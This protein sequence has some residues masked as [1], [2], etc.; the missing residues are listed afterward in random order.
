MEN[1]KTK[2]LVDFI[3][4]NKNIQLIYSVDSVMKLNVNNTIVEFDLLSE[5]YHIKDLKFDRANCFNLKN[6]ENKS[7]LMIIL[8]LLA[9]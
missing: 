4:K 9:A 1:M 6:E 5:R 8:K 7:T 2:D 3:L